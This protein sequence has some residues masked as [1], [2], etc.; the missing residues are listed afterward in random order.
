MKKTII[1]S[2]AGLLF[3]PSTFAADSDIYTGDVVVKASR[4]EQKDTEATYASEIHSSTMIEKSGAASLYDYLARHTSVTTLPSYGNKATPA[5][6]MRGYGSESG[7]ENVV[8]SIDGYRMNNI[9][10]WPQLIGAIPLGSIER[11]EITKGSGSVLY[12][13]GTMAGTIQIYTKASTGV[14]VSASG[15]NFGAKSGYISAGIAEQ[16]IDF[17]ISTSDDSHD[18]FSKKDPLGKKD[19]FDSTSQNFKLAIKPFDGLKLRLEGTTSRT[20]MRYN[21][22]LT[23]AQFRDDPRQNGSQNNPPFGWGFK[24]YT[25]QG[26][27]S[28]RWSTGFEYH[29]TPELKL[30]ARH[31]REDKLSEYFVPY[32]LKRDY[33]YRSND[34]ALQ[35]QDDNLSAIVGYQGFDGEMLGSTN[36]TSKDNSAFFASAEYRWNALSVSVGARREK[37]E[38]TY[39]PSSGNRLNDSEHLNAW[40]IGVNYRFDGA[41][42]VFANYNHAFQTPNIDRFFTYDFF[43]S[44]MT[45]NGFIEPAK[46]KTV[47]FGVNHVNDRHR[48][49]AT[50]FYSDL[51]NEIYYN[52]ALGFFGTNTNIDESHKYGLEL[53]EQFQI[54]EK[55]KA[56]LI[57]TYTRAIIDEEADGGG[58][59]DGKNLPGVSR[60]SIVANI[61]YTLHENLSLNLSH[62]WRSEA[63]ALND[64]ANDF[65][66]KQDSYESTNLALEYRYH[67]MQWFA[68]V[69]NIFKHEN[70][71]QS[72]D[73]TIYPVDF[74]R[75][76][77]VGMKVDF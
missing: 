51:E 10:G 42:S 8:V 60:N 71:I 41:T 31:T 44:S 46:V 36:K 49:K 39:A 45:F 67:N 26:L 65:D 33:D 3:S 57:Y 76:W 12:G 68:A 6:D 40:D 13:D 21:N 14:S 24:P 25:H 72:Q 61:G 5:I 1:A 73:D 18:G 70:E 58:A 52:A 53:Q 23:L 47:N 56:G 34:F 4:F 63:Y 37:V 15:G 27:D 35:F 64:F 19:N 16:Y 2:L 74:S 32:A 9:D 77:R 62:V 11:I 20:D 54:N 75:T 50:A 22:Y 30:T 43:T 7:Y 29:L 28:D 38:Y 55:W 48:F 69:S 66:Q 17:S 59:Y